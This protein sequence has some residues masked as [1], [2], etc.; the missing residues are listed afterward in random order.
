[1]N[2]EFRRQLW[3]HF[4]PIRLAVLPL[5]QLATF[6]AIFFSVNHRTIQ[7]V[8][9]TGVAMFVLLVLLMGTFAAGA[10]VMDEITERTWDQQ[11]MSAMQPWGMTW[12]KLAGA[13]LYAWYGGAVCLLV[14][15]PAALLFE[16]EPS[17]TRWVVG[18]ILGGLFLQSLV[19]AV[20]LQLVRASSVAMRRGGI[21]TPV[22]VLLWGV[23]PLS[24][25]E[26]GALSGIYWWG[27]SYQGPDF[28]LA[29]LFFLTGC[30][31][32]G[33]WRSMAEVLLVRQLPW[34]WP[35]FAL[36]ATVYLGGFSSQEMDHVFW[37]VGLLTCM[38]CTYLALLAEPQPRPVW[39]RV[40]HRVQDGQW[41]EA[42]LQLPRWP[43]TLV[44]ALFF[45]VLATL[46]SGPNAVLPWARHTTWLPLTLVL[47][48][49]RDC[50]AALFFAFSP[51]T[52]QPMFALGV[53]MLVLYALLPW[54]LASA[55]AHPLLKGL[56]LPLLAPTASV[57]VLLALVHLALA[58]G[59]LRW[60]WQAGA[61]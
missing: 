37:S 47:L 22:L 7:A 55:G 50:A 19:L 46:M 17:V 27:W 43:T 20:N 44:L 32:F 9:A 26:R 2:P 23:F 8:A 34:G 58:L 51:S 18:G 16:D 12:G 36:V 52:R 1:M 5:L 3:L 40:V 31:L 39:Q 10:S 21:W 45:A 42:A 61:P 57:S 15:V 13:T 59:L 53:L 60:R 6:A 28:G 14:A 38:G 56:A 33:A 49:A 11:R 35:V 4:S 25:M 48:A 41:R 30:A 24:V 29:T 54:L